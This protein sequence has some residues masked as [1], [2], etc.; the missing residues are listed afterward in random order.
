M[1]NYLSS[2][3][4]CCDKNI[5][6]KVHFGSQFEIAINHGG[7]SRVV[8]GIKQQEVETTGHVAPTVKMQRVVDACGQST[9]L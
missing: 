2:S 1:E 3:S 7:G 8:G 9:F 5:Q 6:G 4:C